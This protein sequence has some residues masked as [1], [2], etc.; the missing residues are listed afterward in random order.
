MNQNTPPHVHVVTEPSRSWSREPTGTYQ[1]SEAQGP[2]TEEERLAKQQRREARRQ[3]A[4]A[5]VTQQEQRRSGALP[6]RAQHK[7][8]DGEELVEAQHLVHERIR[9][10]EAEHRQN[11]RKKCSSITDLVPVRP[12][13]EDVLLGQEVS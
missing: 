7:T 2:L 1:I 3:N 6:P 11:L 9:A 4:G 12:L 8:L 13:L 5:Y 10:R